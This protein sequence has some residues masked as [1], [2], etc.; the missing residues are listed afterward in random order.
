MIY[1]IG[2][3]AIVIL[4]QAIRKLIDCLFSEREPEGLHSDKVIIGNGWGI[5][6][7]EYVEGRYDI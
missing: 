2:L 7:G 6:D 3:S 5:Y 4:A 1:Y